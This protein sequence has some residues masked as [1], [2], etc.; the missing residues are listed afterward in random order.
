MARFLNISSEDESS[1]N[2]KS[3]NC[4]ASDFLGD[5]LR[6]SNSL[7]KDKANAINIIKSRIKLTNLGTCT[8]EDLLYARK[9]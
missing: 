6:F 3:H 4:E 5:G 9:K 2:T 7:D 8:L 1:K